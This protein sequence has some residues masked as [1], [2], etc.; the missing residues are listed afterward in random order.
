MILEER[1]WGNVLKTRKCWVWTGAISSAGYGQIV[2]EGKQYGAHRISWMLHNPEGP[3]DLFVLHKCDRPECV[4]P[5]HLKLG[6]QKD[7]MQDRD[8]K[9]RGRNSRK[10]HCHRGHPFSASNTYWRGSKR[11]CRTCAAAQTKAYYA[12]NKEQIN[13]NRRKGR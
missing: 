13:A 6:T 11:D 7:N 5:S 1:F 8:R 3:G 12:A 10:T 2:Y 4:R 9:K